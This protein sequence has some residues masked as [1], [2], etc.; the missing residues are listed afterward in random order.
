MQALYACIVDYAGG[1]YISQVTATDERQALLMW[2][3]HFAESGAPESVWP[4]A[5][6]IRGDI[7]E[8]TYGIDHPVALTGLLS[9]WC[10]SSSYQDQFALI[11]IVKTAS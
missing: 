11:N 8:G 7:V 9:V 2:C 10:A 5:D 6:E 4:L 1:T 3:D